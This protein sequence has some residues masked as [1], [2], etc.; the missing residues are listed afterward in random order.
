MEYSFCYVNV[1]EI[2]FCI[3][4]TLKIVTKATEKQEDATFIIYNRKYD[5][6]NKESEI[7]SYQS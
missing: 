7:F 6:H 1:Q 4:C 3:R 2:T 5:Y